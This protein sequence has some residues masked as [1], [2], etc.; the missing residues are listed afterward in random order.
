MRIDQPAREARELVLFAVACSLVAWA[1]A[2]AVARWPLPLYP[3]ADFTAD[4]WYVAGFKLGFMLGG[5]LFWL[6]WRG[7]GLA[8][9]A[10]DWRP[11][12]RGW[13]GI[14]LALGAGVLLN[15][16]H[17]APLR[18]LLRSGVPA[19]RLAFGVALPLVSAAI[20]EELA[21]RA[22]LQ[23]RLERAG[24][25]LVAI[26]LSAALFTAWHLPSRFLLST[27]VEGSAGDLASIL[28]GTALPVF[29][30]GLVFA[31]IWDRWRSI[32]PLVALHFAIDL[33]PAL[34]HAAGGTF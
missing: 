26:G 19:T 34:R 7:Y 5:S 10:G 30:A 28:R 25:R 23:T 33:L 29:A 20:P 9:V 15:A 1:A 6:R 17:L 8:D 12:L 27:G 31:A 4:A 16:Q 14:G 22:L 3:G 2:A 24:G 32:L 21:F 13:L 18:D 11:T